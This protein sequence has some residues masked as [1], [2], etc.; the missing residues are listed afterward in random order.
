MW[1][2]NTNVVVLTE[3]VRI[4][5]TV[6]YVHRFRTTLPTGSHVI[7]ENWFTTQSQ[8]PCVC[9]YGSSMY[10]RMC[11]Y[12]CVWTF[13]FFLLLFSIL[14]S[15]DS[16]SSRKHHT[17]RERELNQNR[18]KTA[19]LRGMVRIRHTNNNNSNDDNW[20]VKQNSSI[21]KWS[22]WCVT[23]YFDIIY[24]FFYH[25]RSDLVTKKKKE[26]TNIQNIEIINAK[27]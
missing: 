19:K 23:A 4:L 21:N 9:L 7:L 15:F 20:K 12:A 16:N 26:K 17:Q 22:E 24:Q 1:H 25:D 8:Q 5:S 14:P 18:Q 11:A 6:A 3:V 10:L 2:A 27:S 13:F